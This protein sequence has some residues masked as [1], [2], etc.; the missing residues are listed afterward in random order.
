MGYQSSKCNQGLGPS[1]LQDCYLF[2]YFFTGSLECWE[3][4]YIDV[5]PVV[6]NERQYVNAVCLKYFIFHFIWL[7]E[8]SFNQCSLYQSVNYVLKKVPSYVELKLF[9]CCN[10]QDCPSIYF[11]SHSYLFLNELNL[12]VQIWSVWTE[13]LCPGM[14]WQN[15]GRDNKIKKVNIPR[16][17]R[18]IRTGW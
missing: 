18:T 8:A 3:E 17:T 13:I 5:K 6:G 16:A 15:N 2:I 7:G 14:Y 11:I 4:G 10:F 9:S 12:P 1:L